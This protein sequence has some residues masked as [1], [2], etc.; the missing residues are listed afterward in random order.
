MRLANSVPLLILLAVSA[1]LAPTSGAQQGRTLEMEAYLHDNPLHLVPERFDAKVGDNLR[2]HVLNQ[3]TSPHD[4]LFCGDERHGGSDCSDRW[5][6]AS[7][8]PGGEANLT[9]NVKKAG[10][11]EFFCSIP[12][13]KQGG[14]RADLVV[15]GGAT[16]TKGIPASGIL[17]G[18]GSAGLAALLFRR[19]A[20]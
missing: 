15:Q 1:L 9:V 14:M 5:A 6:F 18:V 17:A 2:V 8:P 10:T 19:R 3:G 20:R 4:I 7:L 11:L 13:H 16:Q 12:G